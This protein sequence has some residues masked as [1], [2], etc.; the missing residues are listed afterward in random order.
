MNVKRAAS[1]WEVSESMVRKIC[2]QMQ[3][4]PKNIPE[5]T[6]PVYIPDKR[7]TKDPHR[8]YVFVLDV[9]I[10]SHLEL[11]GIDPDIIATC[12]EQLRDAGLIV[13]KHGRTA[14]SVDYHD[15][16]VSANRTE[17]Y[18]WKDAKIK[19]KIEMITPVVSAAFE[20]VTAAGTMMAGVAAV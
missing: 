12:V 20:G 1:L 10:N 14:G 6:I 13:L 4:D 3:L 7:Y 16:M 9:I 19:S 8:F 2:K 11:E 5:D 18:N 17:F 15:F